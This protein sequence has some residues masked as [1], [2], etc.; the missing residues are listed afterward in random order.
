MARRASRGAEDRGVPGDV[1]N[2]TSRGRID[3]SAQTE[4]SQ[5]ARQVQADR[6]GQKPDGLQGH[7]GEFQEIS[8]APARS[9]SRFYRKIDRGLPFQPVGGRCRKLK[10]GF[11]RDAMDY[12]CIFYIVNLFT[13]IL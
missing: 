9:F 2:A 3:E 11:Y 10:L 8:G 12:V 13:R 6:K 1:Q 7:R 5:G 4:V